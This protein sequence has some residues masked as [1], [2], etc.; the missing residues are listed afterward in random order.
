[1]NVGL[2]KSRKTFL[3][4]EALTRHEALRRLRGK[5]SLP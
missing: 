1:M 4:Y 2:Y 3:Q 5:V